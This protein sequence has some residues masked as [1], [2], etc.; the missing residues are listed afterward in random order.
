MPDL[1][2]ITLPKNWREIAW[3]CNSH[4][5]QLENFVKIPEKNSSGKI[6]PEFPE[7]NP[8][9]YLKAHQKR[10][11]RKLPEY[12]NRKYLGFAR[13]VAQKSMNYERQPDNQ[14]PPPPSMFGSKYFR[15]YKL[16]GKFYKRLVDLHK[17]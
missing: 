4:F 3:K 11:S 2:V 13:E 6:A 9:V 10:K 12:H 1:K 8:A 7:K 14:T 5:R 16:R 17:I 15:R